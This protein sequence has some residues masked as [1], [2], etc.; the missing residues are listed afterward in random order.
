M[1]HKN[2][3]VLF[4]LLI[5]ASM[6]LGSCAP[7]ATPETIVET[8]IVTEVVEKEGETIIETQVVEV[9]VTKEVEVEVEVPVDKEKVIY[10]SYMSDP[11]PRAADAAA[12]EMY[13]EA[14]PNVDVIHSTVAHEDFK[15]AIRAY[16]TASTPPDVM[17]WF[18]GNRARFFIDN[19]LIMDQRPVGERR[20]E[21]KLPQGVPGHVLR[22]RAAVFRAHL[23]VLVGGLLPQVY[24]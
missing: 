15:Q 4:S 20:L 17:T 6:V 18:A 12:V 3:F 19:G 21:R 8:V 22:G 24:L 11:D 13:M 7:A 23:L 10:N 16:L 14:N 2:T 1:K 9:E 5:V